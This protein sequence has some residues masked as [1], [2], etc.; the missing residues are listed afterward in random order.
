MRIYIFTK[1]RDNRANGWIAVERS[2]KKKQVSSRPIP[3]EHRN[4]SVR[5]SS[6]FFPECFDRRF[7]RL[8][9]AHSLFLVSSRVLS[10]DKDRLAWKTWIP[11]DPRMAKV[12]GGGLERS[13]QVKKTSSFSVSCKTE[14]WNRWIKVKNFY[15]EDELRNKD[16][17][18]K[19]SIEQKYLTLDPV[20]F[21]WI[22]LSKSELSLFS[23]SLIEEI[24]R[25]MERINFL[26]I[27]PSNKN[28]EEKYLTFLN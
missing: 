15:E 23:I 20:Y 4:A 2:L 9:R 28:I 8:P 18:E 1:R 6:S 19:G 3:T 12:E 27:F 10:R 11:L 14:I 26:R 24:Y 7:H 25:I 16:D 13:K 21:F 22:D 5:L 17:R